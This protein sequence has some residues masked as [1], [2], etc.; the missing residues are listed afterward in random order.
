LT[1]ASPRD[2][3][4]TLGKVLRGSKAFLLRVFNLEMFG[5]ALGQAA[6]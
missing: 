4:H 3:A 5:Y 1:G 6:A 2:R